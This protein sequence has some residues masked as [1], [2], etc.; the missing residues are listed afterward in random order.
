M[1]KRDIE[2]EFKR[3]NKKI[4]CSTSVV[5]GDTFDDFPE[6]G[7]PNTI[8]IALNNNSL[9]R[10]NILTETYVSLFATAVAPVS[11]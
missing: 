2:K 9:H 10:W 7:K 11:P 6:V 8:Y 3:L 4:C 1:T 5:E